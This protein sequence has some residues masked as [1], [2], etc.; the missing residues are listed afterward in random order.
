MVA[1]VDFQNKIRE[2]SS[3]SIGKS[4]KELNEEEVGQV[5]K[6][7]YGQDGQTFQIIYPNV[8]KFPGLLD[9]NKLKYNFLSEQQVLKPKKSQQVLSSRSNGLQKKLVS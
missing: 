2:F 1:D 6:I 4:A 9:R 7:G 3:M 5:A 8:D